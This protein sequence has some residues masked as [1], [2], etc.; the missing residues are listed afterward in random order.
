MMKETKGLYLAYDVEIEMCDKLLGGK[1]KTEEL[2]KSWLEARGRV[3][4]LEKEVAEID[5]VEEEKKAWT[6][7]KKDE[8]GLCIDSYQIKG[9]VKEVIKVLKLA[10]KNRGLGTLIK[11]GFFV[12]P[13][14]IHLRNGN[15]SKHPFKIKQEVDGHIEEAVQ[16]SGPQGYRSIIKRHDFV[17]N[18]LLSFEIKFFDTGMLSEKIL[19]LIFEAGQEVGLGT[20]RHEGG[21]FGRFK[22]LK[23][24]KKKLTIHP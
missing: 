6:G 18:A 15:E 5:T 10:Q 9:M 16:V 13:A 4:T 14:H 2:I 21:E 19:R 20:N 17:E 22:V 7:F 11:S 3:G 24:E 23:L 1:P 12:Y 8:Q